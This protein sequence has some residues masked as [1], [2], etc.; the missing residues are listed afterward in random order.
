MKKLIAALLALLMLTA[1]AAMA[2]SALEAIFPYRYVMCFCSQ[3]VSSLKQ[4]WH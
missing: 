3:L 1:S 2:D 4:S